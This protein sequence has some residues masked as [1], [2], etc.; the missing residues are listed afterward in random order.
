[1]LAPTSDT[2]I[3]VSGAMLHYSSIHIPAGVTVRLVAP[4]FGWTS[5]PGMP[6]VVL[7]DGDAIVHG[8][9]SVSGNTTSEYPAGWV[10]TGEGL[11]GYVCGG[12]S[13][14][15]SPP[16]G[17]AHAGTY[18]LAIPFSLDGGSFGGHLVQYQWCVGGTSTIVWGGAGGGTL[19][20]ATQGR[21]EVHGMITGDGIHYGTM[22][23]QP[24]SSGGGS[25][26]SILLRGAGGVTILPTGRVTARGGTALNAHPTTVGAPG[27][28]RLDAWGT[29]PV[30]QGTVDP[31]PTALEL[32]HLRTQ[33]QPRI[34]Q[35]W[36]LDVLA[37]ENAPIYVAAS[38]QP[39]PGTPTPFG[40]LGL[41]LPTSASLAVTTAQPSHDPI[42][43]VPWSIPNAPFLIGLQLWVQAFVIPPSL[44]PRLSNTLHAVVQ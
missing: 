13:G 38:L 32:P 28:I 26:G 34:G 8:T 17:A 16:E 23:P 29:P 24:S 22:W 41:D 20:L 40:S 14:W 19:V 33:S 2:T 21:I 35:T 11:L 30:I 3:T 15:F 18:G 6:A 44:P 25:G 1:M 10:T 43:T 9:L 42:A 36:I 37:P 31:P 12:G 39:G 5:V 27:Y 4:G 7:C